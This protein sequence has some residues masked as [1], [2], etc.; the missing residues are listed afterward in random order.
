MHR[1]PFQ[2][3]SPLNFS[4]KNRFA[5]T[6]TIIFFFSIMFLASAAS[7]TPPFTELSLSGPPCSLYLYTS[8][9]DR[10][11]AG[12]L[13]TQSSKSSSLFPGKFTK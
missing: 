11:L 6:Y 1:F 8:P 4:L 2:A 5:E 13:A 9:L 3:I 7:I 12:S 10:S